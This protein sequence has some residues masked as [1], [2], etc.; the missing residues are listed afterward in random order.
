[1]RTFDDYLSEA[2][3]KQN[4]AS[5]NQIAALLGI[6]G[7]SISRLSKGINL[8]ADETMLKLAKLAGISKDEALV[9]LAIWR[10]GEN[11]EALDTWKDI[12]HKLM[13]L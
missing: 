12:A 10:A 9:D 4:V 11:S 8:P 5:N 6:S 13:M 1:M 3:R 7:T 2:R